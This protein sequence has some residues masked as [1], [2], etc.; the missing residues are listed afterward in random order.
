MPREI[1]EKYVCPSCRRFCGLITDDRSKPEPPPC[2]RKRCP[3]R[4]EL[5]EPDFKHSHNHGI[6]PEYKTRLSDEDASPWSEIAEF[7]RDQ[8]P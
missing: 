5:A 6:Q 3:A 2:K 7:I 4:D 8:Q 1:I